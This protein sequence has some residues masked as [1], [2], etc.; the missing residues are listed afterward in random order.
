MHDVRA[1]VSLA[2]S[3]APFTVDCCQYLSTTEQLTLLDAYPMHDQA[4]HRALHIDDLE[5]D[6][7]AKNPAG[8][9]VLTARFRVERG[10][11][12][13]DLNDVALF[14]RLG[15]QLVDDDAADLRL[16]AELGVSRE[17]SRSESAEVAINLD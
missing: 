10:L 5:L 1:G 12:Q 8:V 2:R 4:L 17:G 13:D 3:D 9:G 16:R 14:G 6:T 11:L 7:V 15:E